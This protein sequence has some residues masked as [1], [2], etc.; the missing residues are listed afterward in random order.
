MRKLG[1]LMQQRFG[2]RDLLRFEVTVDKGKKSRLKTE[3]KS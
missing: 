2:G 1:L 3:K